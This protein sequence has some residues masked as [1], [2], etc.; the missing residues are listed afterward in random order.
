[1]A[2]T[3]TVE[4]AQATFAEVLEGV[5]CRS[6]PVIIQ[7]NGDEVA[8]LISPHHYAALQRFEEAAWLSIEE[9]GKRKAHMDPDEVYAF[10][11][12]EVEAVRQELYDKRQ[13]E[14]A[15]GE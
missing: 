14:A 1:M 4:E 6:E 15:R 5:F 12:A 10:V 13:R 7:R 2:R 11:T 8:V 9:L 3:I